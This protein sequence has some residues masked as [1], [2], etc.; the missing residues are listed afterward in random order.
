MD[1]VNPVNLKISKLG[2]RNA[3]PHNLRTS[4][5]VNP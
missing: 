3:E 5:P 2:T 1:G 4:L